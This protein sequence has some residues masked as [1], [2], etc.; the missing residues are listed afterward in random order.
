MTRQ[1]LGKG[2]RVLIPEGKRLWGGL[3]ARD[4]RRRNRSQSVSTRRAFDDEKLEQLAE[5]IKRHGCWSP[6]WRPRD[7][8]YELVVGNAAGVL[9]S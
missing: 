2:L 4:W 9:R 6:L 5:S 3:L 1:R 7:G 8:G